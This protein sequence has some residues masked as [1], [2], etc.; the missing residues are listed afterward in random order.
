MNRQKCVLCEHFHNLYYEDG[1]KAGIGICRFAGLKKRRQATTG[2]VPIKCENFKF[3]EEKYF[4]IEKEK[5][6]C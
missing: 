2:I 3:S 5:R 4:A 1:K 6:G